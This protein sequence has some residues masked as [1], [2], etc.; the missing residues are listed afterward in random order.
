HGRCTVLHARAARGICL[1]ATGLGGT[2]RRHSVRS[3]Y[4]RQSAHAP[5]SAQGGPLV[6]LFHR[7]SA[8]SGE[9]VGLKPGWKAI[10]PIRDPRQNASSLRI[11]PNSSLPL[12][13]CKRARRGSEVW[14]HAGCQ[15]SSEQRISPFGRIAFD[16]AHA[17]QIFKLEHDFPSIFAAD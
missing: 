7:P 17:A 15:V 12:L 1:D 8:A 6:E 2:I 13:A 10:A 4:G 11:T 9:N 14:L 16:A 3:L 5:G